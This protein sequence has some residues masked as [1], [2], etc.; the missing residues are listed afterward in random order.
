ML[1]NMRTPKGQ[2]C[3]NYFDSGLTSGGY[4]WDETV[5]RLRGEH[6]LYRGDLGWL[7]WQTRDRR[8]SLP[9]L[10]ASLLELIQTQ[11]S[12]NRYWSAT[13]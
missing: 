9:K 3:A 13:A 10:K 5:K 8:S 11:K 12:T 6:E 7:Q 4:V 2:R 1:K